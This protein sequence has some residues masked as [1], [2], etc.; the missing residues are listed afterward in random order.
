LI[1]YFL[2]LDEKKVTKKNHGCICF[3]TLEAFEKAERPKLA[4]TWLP[5]F[6]NSCLLNIFSFVLHDSRLRQLA[7]L[8]AFSACSSLKQIR[9]VLL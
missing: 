4:P 2:F 9:P 7:V 6:W 5:C 8:I 3:F 1:P